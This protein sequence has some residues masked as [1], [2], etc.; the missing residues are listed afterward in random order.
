MAQPP[1]ETIDAYKVL[2][3]I[4]EE[5]GTVNPYARLLLQPEPTQEEGSQVY[6]EYYRMNIPNQIINNAHMEEWSILSTRMSYPQH[7]RSNT[8]LHV[9]DSP[10]QVV[11][12]SKDFNKPLL[13]Y[14]GCP[15]TALMQDY[16]DCYEE[17]HSY[18]HFD[19]NYDD[20]KDVT[21]T[22]LGTEHIYKTD[23]FNPEPSVPIYSNSHTLGQVV[24]GKMLNILIDT[25]AAKCYMSRNYYDKNPALHK[26]PKFKTKVLKLQ[27]GNGAQI[28]T[29][30]V[31]PIQLKIQHHRFEIYTLVANI[32][33]SI[34]MVLGM[35]NMHELEAEHSSRHSEFRVMN[36]AI[37]MFP[38]DN[39]TLKPGNKRFV[40]FIV[41]FFSNLT[42]KAIV[43]LTIGS[44][45]FTAQCTLKDNL[46]VIDMVNTSSHPFVFT[47]RKAFGIV[48]I[49]S[50]GY[51]NI[52]HSTLQYNLSIS[53]YHHKA[54]VHSRH[55]KTRTPKQTCKQHVKPRSA[56]ADRYP[57]LDK[58]DPRRNMTDEEILDTYIDLSKST[59]TDKEKQALMSVIKTHKKAFSLRDEIGN[60]PNI[61][62]DIDV[63]D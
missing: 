60:C 12:W 15:K 8:Y 28:K 33:D 55:A 25:E 52:R 49:R 6:T 58:K 48:D 5:E 44:T 29:H 31:I 18:L 47:D 3:N 24:G 27:V 45:V 23:M 16:L 62:I 4:I 26:L 61:K 43:K 20:N 41:P 46:G 40:K 39:F 36:R 21:T 53:N 11:Q 10:D 54:P 57:W 42:G 50:L 38:M 2:E 17:V 13:E 9:Q 34:D 37:P 19:E 32:E 22:Y 14:Q 63:I 59:L 56:D 35:K 7:S 30:F 51:Y 1:P